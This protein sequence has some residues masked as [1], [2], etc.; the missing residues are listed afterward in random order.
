MKKETKGDV[1]R[2]NIT[3]PSN[4]YPWIGF[5][6]HRYGIKYAADPESGTVEAR[7]PKTR[8]QVA[9]EIGEEVI[10]TSRVL[11]EW[12]GEMTE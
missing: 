4:T 7:R 9:A 2:I 3:P 12:F 10:K 1:I 6:R 8:E 5:W 11:S